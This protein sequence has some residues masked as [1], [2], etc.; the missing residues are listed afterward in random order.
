MT[1]NYGNGRHEEHMFAM[2]GMAD[3]S[4]FVVRSGMEMGIERILIQNGAKPADA[5]EAATAVYKGLERYKDNPA[6]KKA[7]FITMM[8]SPFFK[9]PDAG[10]AAKPDAVKLNNAVGAVLE[11]AAKTFGPKPA[12]PAAPA[13]GVTG[14]QTYNASRPKSTF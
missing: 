1:R 11:M 4:K 8:I 12:A 14:G 10:F 3:T 9:D 13:T 2:H 5:A 7:D 6:Q